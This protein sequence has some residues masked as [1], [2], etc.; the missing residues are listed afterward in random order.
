MDEASIRTR[1]Q[2]V[3]DLAA[4]DVISIRTG[5]ANP[6]LVEN[7]QVAVY[8]GQ[9]KMKVNEVATISVVDPQTLI[10]D[11]WDKTIIG[12]IRQGILAANVGLNPAIDGEIMRITIAPMT[13][14]DREKL[15][16][17]LHTKLENARV[18]IRQVRGD[19]M[20]DIKERF[21]DRKLSEDEK[22]HK[23]KLLQAIT[24]DFVGKIDELG[25]SKEEELLQI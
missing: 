12:E 2:Q 16:K 7:L 1:M 24:D 17:L 13:S 6:G 11:P 25:K 20:K 9:Q 18:M 19:A 3:L 22:F 4:S 14:E 15:V 23:E 8:G 21:E 10:I 5:R